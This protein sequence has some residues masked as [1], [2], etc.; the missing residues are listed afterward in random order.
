MSLFNEFKNSI[1]VQRRNAAVQLMKYDFMRADYRATSH[2]VF[3]ITRN[4]LIKTCYHNEN[5]F[6]TGYRPKLL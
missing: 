6:R 4:N 3:V 2:W 1:R 5:V